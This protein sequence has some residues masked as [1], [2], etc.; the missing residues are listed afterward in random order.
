MRSFKQ[1]ITEV[2]RWDSQM[3]GDDGG[4]VYSVKHLYDYANQV[5]GGPVMLPIKHT[6]GIEWWHK[7]YSLENPGHVERMQ[8][9]DTTVP[10]LAI[11]TGEDQYTV[12]D[13]LNRIKKA[14]SVEGKT[15]V[16]AMVLKRQQ[17]DDFKSTMRRLKNIEKTAG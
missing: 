16:P 6:D 13:G 15:H 11:E 1:Y 9:A 4:N 5:S 3:T 12:A 7:S 8:N 2:E 17:F 10:V 14:H